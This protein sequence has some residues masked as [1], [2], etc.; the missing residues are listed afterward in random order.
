MPYEAAARILIDYG[1]DGLVVEDSPSRSILRSTLLLA[2]RE[3][4]SSRSLEVCDDLPV[5]CDDAVARF[6]ALPLSAG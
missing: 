3:I 6:Q 5:Y 1:R 4:F 2:E